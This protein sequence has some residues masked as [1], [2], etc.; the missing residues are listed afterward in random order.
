MSTLLNLLALLKTNSQ[1]AL[2][3]AVG[4]VSAF[5][6]HWFTKEHYEA[7]IASERE[8]MAL[9]VKQQKEDYEKRISTAT[10]R[11]VLE[12]RRADANRAERDN[13]L[14]RLRVANARI[15]ERADSNPDRSYRAEYAR[16]RK[17]LEEGAELASEGSQLVGRIA[18]EKD[19]LSEI[20]K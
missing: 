18:T 2:I 15:S 5:G 3:V 20:V 17:F 8:Q 7:Q 6:G 1:T 19:A 16:C 13:L 4:I 10:S 9:A 14:D 12:S 11:L